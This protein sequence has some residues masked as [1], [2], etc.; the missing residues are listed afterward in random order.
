MAQL[1]VDTVNGFNEEESIWLEINGRERHLE[2]ELRSFK[3][4]Q[5]LRFD[6]IANVRVVVRI[7]EVKVE[8]EDR[9]TYRF[10][11][12]N[13]N[14]FAQYD[15]I[16]IFKSIDSQICFQRKLIA[17]PAKITIRL[18][19]IAIGDEAD[20]YIREYTK[21]QEKNQEFYKLKD[22]KNDMISRLKMSKSYRIGRAITWPFR[23]LA[24]LKKKLIKNSS[25][26]QKG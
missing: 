22:D 6:P 17:N 26:K 16:L 1:F 13:S 10:S 7:D 4:I 9:R 12:F 21:F 14:E 25:F 15:N 3:D 2:F 19:Y 8:D 20:F 24:K 23:M 11:N 18:E 5:Q